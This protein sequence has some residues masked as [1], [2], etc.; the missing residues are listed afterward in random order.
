MPTSAFRLLKRMCWISLVR[1]LLGNGLRLRFIR[2]NHCSV[3]REILYL[4]LF[5][6]DM[7]RC[8]MRWKCCS[9]GLH[10]VCVKTPRTIGVLGLVVFSFLIF[11]FALCD[12]SQ[13]FP[14]I[15]RRESLR[16]RACRKIPSRLPNNSERILLCR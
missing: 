3:S 15:R 9:Y 1:D 11:P 10:T 5:L 6:R 12:R 4:V 8:N 16:L 2:C 14:N 7:S 13:S